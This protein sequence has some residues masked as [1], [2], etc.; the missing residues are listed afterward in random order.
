MGL[1]SVNEQIAAYEIHDQLVSQPSVEKVPNPFYT[2][3]QSGYKLC[4]LF[5]STF[6]HLKSF[7]TL[8]QWNNY[9]GFALPYC[10]E[11]NYLPSVYEHHS[12]FH[13]CLLICI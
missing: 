10:V 1:V 13:L 6:Q 5:S 11:K 4:H 12:P 3:I 9:L 2:K 7:Q 8:T